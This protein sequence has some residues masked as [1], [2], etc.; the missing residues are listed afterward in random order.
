MIGLLFR[1]CLIIACFFAG[2]LF[3][4]HNKGAHQE[5]EA[6]LERAEDF[7]ET[8]LCRC[9]TIGQVFSKKPE[10]LPVPA[11]KKEI[12]EATRSFYA[13]YLYTFLQTSHQFNA[14]KSGFEAGGYCRVSRGWL[15]GVDATF[16]Q[17][18]KR[19]IGI[20]LFWL[21]LYL[22][23][24]IPLES[25]WNIYPYLG[26]VTQNARFSYPSIKNTF[27]GLG[28]QIG[29]RFDVPVQDPLFIEGE[30]FLPIAFGKNCGS[31]LSVPTA[32]GRLSFGSKIKAKQIELYLSAGFKGAISFGIPFM[33][34][35]TSYIG[36][37]ARLETL[38]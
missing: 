14:V 10:A 21:D 31:W 38:F 25:R 11:Q 7:Y 26:V 18:E 2:N 22:G 3:L 33:T 37:E 20:H 12:F 30:F 15:A 1:I 29:F 23:R 24:K 9:D 13:G 32:G 27:W 17:G 6:Q 34:Q 4:Q 19:E 8:L 16:V 5:I 28:P 35:N 36:L